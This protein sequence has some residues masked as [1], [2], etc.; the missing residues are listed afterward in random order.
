MMDL[1]TAGN[2]YTK[3]SELRV[4]RVGTEDLRGPIPANQ[5]SLGLARCLALE[6]VVR[7]LN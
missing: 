2:A 6:H 4:K 3:I 5:L 1:Q 7:N